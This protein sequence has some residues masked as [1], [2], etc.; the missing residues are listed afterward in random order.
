MNPTRTVAPPRDDFV[1]L[2]FQAVND[3]V[4]FHFVLLLSRFIS[5]EIAHDT[6][7]AKPH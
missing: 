2:T 5:C 4:D 1:T 3:V 6:P 7:L